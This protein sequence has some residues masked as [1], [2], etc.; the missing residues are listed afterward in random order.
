MRAQRFFSTKYCSVVALPS[1]TSW[2]HCSRGNLMPN[3]LSM[4]KAMSRKS[5]LSISRSLI[6]WLSGLMFSRGM[7]QVSA[8]ISATLSNVVD[9]GIALWSRNGW[10]DGPARRKQARTLRAP[11]VDA[12]IAKDAAE[13]N[14][15]A[16][17]AAIRSNGR[18]ETPTRHIDAQVV[19]PCR[20]VFDRA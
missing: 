2:V 18:F 10:G 19:A 13:F 17:P 20:P 14:G 15:G 12:L 9:I 11:Q 4:A 7:S 16:N 1:L 5:R 8:M 6:A 3:A